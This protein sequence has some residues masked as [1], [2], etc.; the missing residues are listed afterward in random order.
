M[1]FYVWLLYL[2]FTV[3]IIM[4][5]RKLKNHKTLMVTEHIFCNNPKANEKNPTGFWL[6]E[7][8]WSKL[9]GWPIKIRQ[10]CS[11]LEFTANYITETVYHTHVHL[12]IRY[13]ICYSNSAETLSVLFIAGNI[14]RAKRPKGD[15]KATSTRLFSLLYSQFAPSFESWSTVT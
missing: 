14:S 13:V 6:R 12:Q 3:K 8:G 5:N 15:A 9:P 10:H 7:P 1:A 4:M 11:T 2:G